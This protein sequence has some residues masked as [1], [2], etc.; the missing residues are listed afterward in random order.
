MDRGIISNR[1]AKAI[2]QYAVE[3]KEENRLREEMKTLADRFFDVP[4]LTKVLEDPTVSQAVKIDVLV[5]AAGKDISDT[6]KQV[7]RTVVKNGRARYMQSIALMYD[8]IFRKAK[9][10]VIMKLITT[11]PASAEMENKLVDL[12]KYNKEQVDFETKTDE[13]IIGGFI[14]EIEDLRLDAGIRNQ[15]NQLRLEL[16]QPL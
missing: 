15:L 14:L 8:K 6:C 9:N 16:I 7:I 2:F 1:Y 11:E 3:R 5:N 10:R 12:V 4:M 13:D